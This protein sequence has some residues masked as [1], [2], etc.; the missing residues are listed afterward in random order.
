MNLL[1]VHTGPKIGEHQYHFKLN[2]SYAFL[3][4]PFYISFELPY[5]FDTQNVHQ[6]S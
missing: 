1:R 6:N 4:I 5:N 3:S 2:Y